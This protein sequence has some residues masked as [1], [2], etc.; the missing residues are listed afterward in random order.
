MRYLLTLV[1]MAFLSAPAFAAFQG[2]GTRQSGGFNGPGSQASAVTVEKAKT[3]ADDS[4]V[5]LTGNIVSQ[6]QGEK[7][8]YMFRDATGEIRVDIDHKY[9]NGQDVTPADTVRITGK[10]DND[11]GKAVEIDVKL[12]EVLK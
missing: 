9:F 2:P 10:V 7:D 4:I 6:I 12:L 8:D 11:F 3:L 5:T 1:L